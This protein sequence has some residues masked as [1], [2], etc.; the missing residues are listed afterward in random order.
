MQSDPIPA[1][2]LREEIPNV[3]DNDDGSGNWMVCSDS[4]INA[5]N[6]DLTCLRTR[7]FVADAAL[8]GKVLP[9][10][11]ENLYLPNR[12]LVLRECN[13]TRFGS[14]IMFTGHHKVVLLALVVLPLNGCASG[15]LRMC[16]LAAGPRILAVEGTSAY[17]VESDAPFEQQ[18]QTRTILER[19]PITGQLVPRQIQEIMPHSVATETADVQ[20]KIDVLQLDVKDHE[21]R[22]RELELRNR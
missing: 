17:C 3:Y 10:D 15:S 20:S 14:R 12:E 13:V 5:R 4:R 9:P 21:K 16:P 2:A 11:R 1:L 8:R 7:G 18:I 6:T 19:D 22:I